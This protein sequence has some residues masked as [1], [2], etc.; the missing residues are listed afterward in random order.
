MVSFL[1]SRALFTLISLIHS[2]TA[3]SRPSDPFTFTD[4]KDDPFN[5]LKYIASNVLTGV[6][7]SLIMLVALLQT[8]CIVRWGAKWMLSM[9]IGAYFFALGIGIRFGLHLQPDSKGF[10]ITEYLFV[11]LSPCAF[12]A[13]DYV[14]LGRL[15]KHLGADQHLIISSRII[16][17]VYIAS[18]VITFLIQAVGGAVSAGA[19]DL[20]HGLLGSR[21][22]LAGLVA[23]LVSF[24]SFWFIY[25]L[26]LYRIYKYSPEIW[27]MDK[28]KPWY[29]SWRTLGTVLFI[30]CMGI[31]IRSGFRVSELSQ[32]FD[33]PLTRSESLFYGLDTLPLFIAV[34]LY[35]PFWPGRFIT[36]HTEIVTVSQDTL[37]GNQGLGSMKA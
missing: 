25:S 9:T 26:F 35:I 8:W 3:A 32:G 11:V 31:L 5:P 2:A 13:A 21:I 23:Q 4:P 10:Y 33:G 27:T 15:A 14:L 7:F 24:A 34:L 29:N 1:Q 19:T 22:F 16:T 6:A 36:T 28:A 20:K 17:R 18:D 12:I 37:D 30:S